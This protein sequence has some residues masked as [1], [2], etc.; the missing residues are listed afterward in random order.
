APVPPE[1]NRSGVS[2]TRQ[3]NTHL[4]GKP[5]Q[6][7]QTSPSSLQQTMPTKRPFSSSFPSLQREVT[8]TDSEMGTLQGGK[9]ESKGYDGHSIYCVR[10]GRR[11][12]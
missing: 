4:T 3:T 2:F 9:H 6:R 5:A 12:S 1:T 7:L 8:H 11:F 10:D